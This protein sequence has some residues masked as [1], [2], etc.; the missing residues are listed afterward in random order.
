[1]PNLPKA[2][3]WGAAAV[4][5][6]VMLCPGSGKASDFSTPWLRPDRAL[7]VDAYEYN[8]IDW[9]KL[10]ADKRVVGFISKATHG[11]P[12]PS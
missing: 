7:V 6:A 3:I 8:A 12:P 5:A 1:M 4:L 2:V 11:L 10:S 9:T